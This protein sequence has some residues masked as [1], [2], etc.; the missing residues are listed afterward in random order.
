MSN[1]ELEIKTPYD[2]KWMS[3]AIASN[4][5]VIAC[6]EHAKSNFFVPSDLNI[7]HGLIKGITEGLYL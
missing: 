7:T 5:I 2:K 1:E 6:L 4:C 3:G